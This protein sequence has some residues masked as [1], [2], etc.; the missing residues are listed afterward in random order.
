MQDQH[1]GDERML[2]AL[3]KAEWQYAMGQGFTES[4]L[5]SLRRRQ[6]EF[7]QQ[8]PA[9]RKRIEESLAFSDIPTPSDM[10]QQT[11]EENL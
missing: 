2:D 3:E 10:P 4:E 6:R 11:R 8:W 7:R 5:D 9:T 1:P